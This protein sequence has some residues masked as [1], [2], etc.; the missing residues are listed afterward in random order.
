MWSAFPCTFITCRHWITCPVWCCIFLLSSFRGEPGCGDM[1]IFVEWHREALD[2]RR[3]SSLPMTGEDTGLGALASPL[4]GYLGKVSRAYAFLSLLSLA[5][6]WIIFEIYCDWAVPI[7]IK[8][9]KKN[10]TQTE[11]FSKR[12]KVWFGLKPVMMLG[13]KDCSIHYE[14][15]CTELLPY[16]SI[17]KKRMVCYYYLL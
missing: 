7:Q 2:Q 6:S 12:R 10:K 13:L 5:Q 4:A 11:I 17:L 14:K 15:L 16:L 1:V 8:Q 9:K 3:S